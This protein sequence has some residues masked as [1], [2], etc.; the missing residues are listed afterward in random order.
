M[1]LREEICM[2]DPISGVIEKKV[3]EGVWTVVRGWFTRNRDLKKQVEALQA[4][5]A[6]ERS[7]GL[8]VEKMMSEVEC[9][10]EDDNMYW[11][12]DAK[13]GPYCPL[14]LHDN[15]K[16]IPM[17]QGGREGDFYCRLHDHHFETQ[18]RRE[19]DRQARQNRAQPSRPGYGRHGW[20]R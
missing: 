1:V 3:A 12:K 6:E 8:A 10:T 18:E 4:E 9:R 20:M 2:V 14:C 11:S 17:T 15:Q 7:G 16:L 19:R 5:L 13:G